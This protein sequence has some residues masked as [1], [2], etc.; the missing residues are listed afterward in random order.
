M[1]EREV[2]GRETWAGPGTWA[3][4]EFVDIVWPPL[5]PEELLQLPGGLRRPPWG[6]GAEG[7][8]G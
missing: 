3:S 8:C 2:Q 7:L 5:G 4:I 6:V 1:P